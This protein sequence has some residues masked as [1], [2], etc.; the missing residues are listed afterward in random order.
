MG[1]VVDISLTEMYI[2]K[3][4]SLESSLRI[5]VVDQPCVYDS[6]LLLRPTCT[7]REGISLKNIESES[8][9]LG[10]SNLNSVDY[11]AK[12]A[13]KLNIEK[14]VK[15]TKH[16]VSRV[17]YGL[18]AALILVKAYSNWLVLE[19][20]QICYGGILRTIALVFTEGISSWK[21]GVFCNFQPLVVP[22]GRSTLGRLFNV[23]GSTIDSYLELDE[24]PVFATREDLLTREE[25]N[26]KIGDIRTSSDTQEELGYK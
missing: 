5:G 13:V 17:N 22:V 26:I 2:S 10:L 3:N 1:P 18:A 12:K 6:I 25:L 24:L 20:N 4:R 11:S 21:V 7:F 8:L 9:L 16:S 14:E 15:Q 23:L 19:V